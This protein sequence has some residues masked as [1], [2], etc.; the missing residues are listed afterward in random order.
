MIGEYH[1]RP[2]MSGTYRC[3]RKA[4]LLKF[5]PDQRS[6]LHL[7]IRREEELAYF[8][9]R[10]RSM[11]RLGCAKKVELTSMFLPAKMMR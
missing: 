3:H 9:R 5:P 6:D 7:D 4:F 1:E 8:A 11:G 10:I 2:A